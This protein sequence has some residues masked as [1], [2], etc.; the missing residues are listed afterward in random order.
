MHVAFSASPSAG[1][2]PA[3]S[4]FEVVQVPEASMTA[5]ARSRRPAPLLFDTASTKGFASRP[6]LV[7]LSAPFRVIARTRVFVSIAPVIVRVSASGF[8]YAS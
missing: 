5:R 7:T 6:L 1:T 8:R 2:P 4:G 3:P